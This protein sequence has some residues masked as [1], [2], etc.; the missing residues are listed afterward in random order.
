MYRGIRGKII[1][2]LETGIFFGEI[3]H[4]GWM[5]SFQG[6]SLASA[7]AAFHDAVDEFMSSE[8]LNKILT[9]SE[10]ENLVEPDN[11]VFKHRNRY[12]T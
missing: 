11:D 1:Q 8:D 7:E 2:N 6:D 4:G 5:F 9:D 12:D 3:I 10:N